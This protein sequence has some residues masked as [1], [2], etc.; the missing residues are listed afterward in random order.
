MAASRKKQPEL[1]T[2]LLDQW[3]DKLSGLC[4]FEAALSGGLDSVVLLTLLAEARRHLPWLHLSAVHVHHG[5]SA[6]ADAWEAHCRTLCQSLEVPMRVERVHVARHGGLGIEAAARMARY[7][8]FD[9]ASANVTVLA[10]HRDDQCETQLLQLLRGGGAH[11]LAGMPA[12]RE[13]GSR[14]YWRPLLD[15]GRADLERFALERGLSWVEDDSNVDT[16]FRRNFLRHEIL[17][18]LADY[19]P[20]YPAHMARSAWQLSEAAAVL[21]EVAEADLAACRCDDGLSAPAL[22]ALSSAR[23]GFVLVRWLKE[24]TMLQPAPDALQEFLRQLASANATA[25]PLLKLGDHCL[26]RYRDRLMLCRLAGPGPVSAMQWDG[27]GSPRQIAP[28][29]GGILCWR[30]GK[31]L[32]KTLLAAGFELRPRQGGERLRQSSGLKEVRKLFQEAGVPAPLRAGWPLLFGP[33]DR[34]LAV[35]GIA[36]A[37]DVME[38][39]GCWPEWLP[40]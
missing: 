16:R 6:H 24:R 5:L 22:L 19:L 36:V 38:E 27:E 20:D 2:H 40:L 29:W 26:L 32:P 30:M 13:S 34:L 21:D 17:P 12:L 8:A 10:H 14:W 28:G 3:P 15:V 1:L 39:G 18:R 11:A 35:P 7:A 33:D 37:C 23:R 25:T 31:G 9:K 4:A